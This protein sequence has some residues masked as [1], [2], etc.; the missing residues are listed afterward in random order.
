MTNDRPG[1]ELLAQL[2]Q[3]L[4]HRRLR[5]GLELTGL[6]QELGD[7]SA[8]HQTQPGARAGELFA[9]ARARGRALRIS[10]RNGRATP[11]DRPFPYNFPP[12]LARVQTC[13]SF[14]SP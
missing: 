9:F 11:P 2:A 5:D 3:H 6:A 8:S 1:Q 13:P 4:D 10:A 12:C 14:F 7:P